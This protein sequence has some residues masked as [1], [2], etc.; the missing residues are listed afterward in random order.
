MVQLYYCLVP[1]QQ[2]AVYISMCSLYS[3]FTCLVV[4]TYSQLSTQWAA[5]GR[6]ARSFSLAAMRATSWIWS[7]ITVFTPTFVRQ[8]HGHPSIPSTSAE[9]VLGYPWLLDTTKSN[10]NQKKQRPKSHLFA[11]LSLGFGNGGQ[12]EGLSLVMVVRH[13]TPLAPWLVGHQLK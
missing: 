6:A 12:A 1:L 2:Q 5:E 4:Q 7:M 9:P 8:S 11:C 13:C 3:V 10:K